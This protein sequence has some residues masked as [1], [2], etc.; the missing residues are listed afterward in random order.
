LADRVDH[1]ASQPEALRDMSMRT[2]ALARPDAADVIVDECRR[3]LV[4]GH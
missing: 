3:L 2:L 4:I 1:Y